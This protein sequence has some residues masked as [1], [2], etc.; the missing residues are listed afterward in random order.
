M[1]VTSLTLNENE[2]NCEYGVYTYFYFYQSENQ[3]NL[4]WST[5]ANF[6]TFQDL[7]LDCNQTYNIT[8]Y[9]VMWPKRPLLLDES[10]KFERIFPQNNILNRCTVSHC[11]VLIFII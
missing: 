5:L 11:S 6:N 8:E 7:I 9:L 1:K 10:F 2:I 3:K 4:T